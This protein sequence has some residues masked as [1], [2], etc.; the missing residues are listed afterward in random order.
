MSWVSV[1]FHYFLIVLSIK[2]GQ[3][4]WDTPHQFLDE[5]N[6]PSI[7]VI[8]IYSRTFCSTGHFLIRI[9]SRKFLSNNSSKQNKQVFPRWNISSSTNNINNQTKLVTCRPFLSSLSLKLQKKQFTCIY[10]GMCEWSESFLHFNSSP[11]KKNK[12]ISR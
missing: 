12:L 7:L 4:R 3:N 5:Y 9:M 6:N 1:L 2:L 8:Y 11:I 10:Y